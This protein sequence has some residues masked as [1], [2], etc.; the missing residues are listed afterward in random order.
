MTGAHGGDQITEIIIGVVTEYDFTERL[1]VYIG[2]NAEL[3]DSVW[4]ITLNVLHP[5]RDPKASRSRCLGHI[6]NLAAKA[7]IFGDN[8]NAFEAIVD[9][10]TDLTL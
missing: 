6:I 8:V 1:G 9:I 10:V 5:E 3:N 7:F 4:R 2:D